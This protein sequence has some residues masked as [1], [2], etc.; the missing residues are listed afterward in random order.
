M[1]YKTD[2]YG[3]HIPGKWLEKHCNT[4]IKRKCKDGSHCM[5]ILTLCPKCLKSAERK[6]LVL[7][8]EEEEDEWMGVEQ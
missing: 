8:T 5:S 6:G 1:I 7:H 2:W 4:V 3:H